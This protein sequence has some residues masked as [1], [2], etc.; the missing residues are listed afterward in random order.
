ME[1]IVILTWKCKECGDVVVSTSDSRHSINV[2]ECGKSG[3]D[4]EEHYQRSFGCP[5]DINIE[6]IKTK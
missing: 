6:I 1:E 4:L 2:C 3:V 5:E